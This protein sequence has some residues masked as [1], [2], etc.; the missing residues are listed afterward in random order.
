MPN[1]L[2]T[3]TALVYFY[4]NTDSDLIVGP[5]DEDYC[6]LPQPWVSKQV[7]PNPWLSEQNDLVTITIEEDY[8]WVGTVNSTVR[9][10]TPIIDEGEISVV[11]KVDEDFWNI[12]RPAI[13]Q[14]FILALQDED[15]FTR[16]GKVD[17]DFYTPPLP[18]PVV[19]KVPDV[20]SYEP[21]DLVNLFVDEDYYWVVVPRVSYTVPVA[22]VDESEITIDGNGD[23]D[24]YAL[25]V[26]SQPTL[27]ISYKWLEQGDA[28]F[29]A[30][31]EDYYWWATAKS[32]P[33]T[34]QAFTDEGEFTRVGSGDED[35]WAVPRPS[36]QSQQQQPVT[37]QGDGVFLAAEE[38]YWWNWLVRSQSTYVPPITDESEIT[39]TGKVEEDYY[40]VVL[41]QITLN[42]RLAYY[43][44]GEASLA[45]YRDEDYYW[46]A[47]VVS[48][49][50]VPVA[51]TDEG[52]FTL[53]SNVDEDGWVVARP[54]LQL[55]PAQPAIDQGDAVWLAAEE[56]YW[57]IWVGKQQVPFI[58]PVTDESEIT[59]TGRVDE[60]YYQLVLPFYVTVNRLQYADEGEATFGIRGDEDGWWYVLPQTVNTFITPVQDEG[61]FTLVARV[62]EDYWQIVVPQPSVATKLFYVDEGEA[63]FPVRG[64]ED[65]N[66]VGLVQPQSSVPRVVTDEGEFTLFAIVDEDFWTRLV[67]QTYPVSSLAIYEDD[68]VSPLVPEE[69]Y[70]WFVNVGITPTILPKP[71][72]YD[73]NEQATGLYGIFDE[74]FYVVALV[75]R[76]TPQ[77]SVVLVQDEE[78]RP[79]V[80][81]ADEEQ[82]IMPL[83][84]PR[85]IA[86]T[87]QAFFDRTETLGYPIYYI[88]RMNDWLD[89][90]AL[91]RSVT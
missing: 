45:F 29:L 77:T 31:E 87:Q 60:D 14:Q 17:E 70:C 49:Q 66:W 85:V 34:P 65:Y 25:P 90:A 80:L 6:V 41:P 51:T 37:D 20:W 23:E 46:F 7:V 86:V 78:T 76:F 68:V 56:D 11:G 19:N 44:E 33:T 74:D 58:P 13:N 48:T 64:D 63:T 28:V 5:P 71:W 62:D 4:S 26:P 21:N 89:L 81:V 35:G 30:S 36:I 3:P 2:L 59:V 69:D 24:C 82:W 47:P 8:R 39:I 10:P 55:Q 52:E 27:N 91:H 57:Q 1:I 83:N 72:Q 43:D 18:A 16:V 54:W 53:V 32:Q 9:V 88:T 84:M 12:P 67:Q 22:I 61:E 40:Q 15:G 79:I 42:N 50:R 73:Q 38:D 75:P